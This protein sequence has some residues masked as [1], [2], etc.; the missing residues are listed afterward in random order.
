MR[1]KELKLLVNCKFLPKLK[2]LNLCFCKYC[3]FGKQCRQNFKSS[4]H[5]R[6]G[7]LDYIH[8]DVW[9]P[10]LVV[11]FGE[12]SYFVTFIDDYPRKVWIFFIKIKANVFG[13]IKYFRF[14]V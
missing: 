6:K 3:V 14:L 7:I 9:G 2:S 8:V 1:E 5:T 12:A 10:S 13:V 4:I 11:S